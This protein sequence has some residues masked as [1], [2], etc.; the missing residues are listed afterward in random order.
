MLDNRGSLWLVS[1]MFDSLAAR[2]ASMNDNVKSVFIVAV[3]FLFVML[4]LVLLSSTSWFVWVLLGVGW[5]GFT[6]LLTDSPV[7]S[8][9]VGAFWLAGLIYIWRGWIPADAYV[10]VPLS[11]S[12]GLTIVCL[13]AVFK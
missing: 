13:G 4:L 10:G 5:L 6:V 11:L 7:A 8:S 12:A 1:N 3:A 2:W 9:L